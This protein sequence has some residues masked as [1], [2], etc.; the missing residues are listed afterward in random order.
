MPVFTNQATTTT[1]K[2]S[3]T[4]VPEDKNQLTYQLQAKDTAGATKKGTCVIDTGI[5]TVSG[6]TPGRKYVLTV[7]AC[8]S[9]DTS[10]CGASSDA[11]NSYTIPRSKC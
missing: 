7:K 4:K 11:T 1:I 10:I 5:C 3:F 8:I 6:L 2:A 9:Q